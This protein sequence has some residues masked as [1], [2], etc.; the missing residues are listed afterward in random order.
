M[1]STRLR[2]THY[3][4]FIEEKGSSDPVNVTGPVVG[5][6]V[7]LAITAGVIAAVWFYRRRICQFISRLKSEEKGIRGNAE[8]AEY[9]RNEEHTYGNI[10]GMGKE[11]KQI[12]SVKNAS[13]VVDID[14][15]QT[16]E[17]VDDS[18]TKTD[19]T[20][21]NMEQNNHRVNVDN[22][23]KYVTKEHVDSFENEFKKLNNGLDLKESCS[24]ARKPEN[25]ALNR[26][27][28]IYPYNHS[29]VTVPGQPAFY[30]N[31][32]YIDGYNKRKAYIASSG[33][34]AKTTDTFSTFWSMVWN[35]KSD[36]IVMLTNLNEPSGKKCEKYWP[37]SERE[38]L[39]GR[40]KV[41]CLSVEEY[42][43]YTVRTFTVAKVF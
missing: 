1:Q 37:E 15:E 33:P 12:I 11:R 23:L 22:L 24:F 36:I 10:T 13:A 26:Y 14:D 18:A 19:E 21:Y 43:E 29:R 4:H 42:A 38:E 31:A 35:E 5:C 40:V 7:C 17:R 28:G 3:T 25:V 41:K 30:I 16:D 34:T 6:I 27:N 9:E 20:H 8:V 39:Y 2:G 32:C